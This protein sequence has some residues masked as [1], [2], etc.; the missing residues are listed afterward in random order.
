MTFYPK[1]QDIKKALMALLSHNLSFIS[2]PKRHG[3]ILNLSY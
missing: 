1:I 3:D 2:A